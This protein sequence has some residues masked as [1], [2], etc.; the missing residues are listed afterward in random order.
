MRTIKIS[1]GAEKN[2][3]VKYVGNTLSGL[4]K[5]IGGEMRFPRT[6]RARFS[7]FPRRKDTPIT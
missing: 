2:Y 3:G 1:D 5:E 4:I 6:E 7:K